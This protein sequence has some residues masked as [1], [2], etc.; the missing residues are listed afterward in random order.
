MK[1]DDFTNLKISNKEKKISKKKII[2]IALC[3]IFFFIF[4]FFFIFQIYGKVIIVRRDSSKSSSV[5]QINNIRNSNSNSIWAK[6]YHRNINKNNSLTNQIIPKTTVNDTKDLNVSR[7]N[8]SENC[9]NQTDYLYKISYFKLYSKDYDYD[10]IKNIF[11]IKYLVGLYYSNKTLIKPT[12]LSLFYNLSVLCSFYEKE[13]NINIYSIPLFYGDK[14]IECNEYF[15][16]KRTISLRLSIFNEWK[17]IKF[18]VFQI[19]EKESEY[20]NEHLITRDIF[21]KST[22]SLKRKYTKPENR[23]FLMNLNERSFCSCKGVY[24]P[25]I[26]IPQECKFRI[27]LYNLYKNMLVYNKTYYLFEDFIVQSSSA[28]DAYPIFEEMKKRDYPVLYIT[29]KEDIYNKYC[30]GQEFCTTILKANK[31]SFKKYGNFLEKY[32]GI[33]LKLK[34][35]ITNNPNLPFQIPYLFKKLQYITVIGIGHGVNYFKDYLFENNRIY[36]KYLNDKFLIPPSKELV[37]R[38][39]N[40]G[41]DEKDIIKI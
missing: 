2:L 12:D 38:A 33:L 31:K 15:K 18:Q 30:K 7:N 17:S 22:Y 26:V 6:K 1:D 39:V 20:I 10:Q 16:Q 36:G 11:H 8:S 28:D 41:W 40:H 32:L 25:N 29:E 5:N 34:V 23:W 14:Y 27:Y 24:C 4:V 13:H 19:N 3:K 21:T 35:L 9:T 37:S